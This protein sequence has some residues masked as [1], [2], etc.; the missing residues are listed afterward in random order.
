MTDLRFFN[1]FSFFAC[2]AF[3]LTACNN[4]VA[5]DERN[6]QESVSLKDSLAMMEITA[7]N[8]E[9]ARNDSIEALALKGDSLKEKHIVIDKPSFT[10]YLREN[11]ETLMKIPV[12]LG[13]GI[14]QKKKRG[15]HKTPEGKFKII[16][17][18][19]S[20]QWP[21]D[22]HDGRGK[23]KGV[24]GPW[25]FRLNTPQSPHIGIHGTDAPETMGQR[26]SDGCVRLINEDL[27]QLKD[28]VYRGMV[29]VINPD[30]NQK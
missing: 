1:I 11:G 2:F 17:I 7:Q 20:S 21:Y 5:A 14:G 25:F 18:E 8:A 27:L 26:A 16:S 24:Y 30:S 13:R 23:V 19:N 29:V 28:H 6:P 12:C 3:L 22:F 4:N 15:D 9:Q 10:L